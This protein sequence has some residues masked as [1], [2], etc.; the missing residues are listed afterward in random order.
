M[1][2]KQFNQIASI[3][4]LTIL[5]LFFPTHMNAETKIQYTLSFPEP[6]THYVEV[7]LKIS[8]HCK[9]PLDLKMPV[10]TPGSYLVREFSRHVESV[11]CEGGQVDKKAKN[12]WRIIPDSKNETKVYYKVY[13]FE[14]SVRTSFIDED[15]ALLNGASIFMRLDSKEKTEYWIDLLP[16]KAWKKV[17]TTLAVVDENIWRRKANDYDELVDSPILLGKQAIF[18]FDVASVPHKLV[19]AGQANYDANRLTSDIQKICTEATKVIG[20]HPCLEYAFLV[21]NANSSSGGLEHANCCVLHAN[22]GLYKNEIQYGN[23][24]GLVAHEYF[25]LWNVKRIRPIELGPFDYDNE[26]YTTMLWIS[27]GFTSYYDDYI[28]QRAGIISPDRFLDLMVSNISSIENMQGNK[29]QSVSEASFDAWIKY[30]RTNENT[31]NTNTNYY[32]KGAILAM[33]IDLEIISASKGNTCLDDLMRALYQKYYKKLGRGF[34]EA[35]FQKEVENVAGKKMDVFFQQYVHGTEPLDYNTYFEKAGYKLS[36]M[37]VGKMDV[38]LGIST[39]VKEGKTVITSVLR[40]GPAW[41]FGLNVNDE[42]EAI[43]GYRV[44]NDISQFLNTKQAG[45]T[46]KILVNRDGLLRDITLKLEPYST[47]NYRLERIQNPT[48]EQLVARRKWLGN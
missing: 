48:E 1:M 9:K 10:W 26:N 18:S 32:S 24:L 21:I 15:M 22:R 6:H 41:K 28:C 4:L 31:L 35:E 43:E 20:E 36:N 19:M 7:E 34:T 42:I 2:K 37:N 11:R 27:E 29:I 8:G 33:L 25:H 23:F 3:L 39:T 13:A 47:F 38:G 14:L 44:A 17:N 45:D 46:L 12:H 16:T 40:N 30:Y 5:G